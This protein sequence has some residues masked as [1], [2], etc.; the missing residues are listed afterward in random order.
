MGLFLGGAVADADGIGKEIV[1]VVL[2]EL[3]DDHCAAIPAFPPR[4]TNF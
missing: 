4:N 3:D 1:S 2:E